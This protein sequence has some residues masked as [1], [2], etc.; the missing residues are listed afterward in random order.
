[1]SYNFDGTNDWIG[2]TT[3][4][5]VTTFPCT[6]ACWFKFDIADGTLISISNAT[7]GQRYRL[8]IIASSDPTKDIGFVRLISTAGGTDN[9]IETTNHISPLVWGHACAVIASATSRTV[10][11][12]AADS[13]TSTVSRSVTGLNRLQI[14]SGRESSANIDYFDGQIADVGIWDR[15]LTLPEI[16][17]LARGVSCPLVSV[18]NLVFHAPLIRDIVDL[19]T[20]KLAL[21]NNGGATVAN[22]PRIYI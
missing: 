5:P 1:M 6:L 8:R 3:T 9:I 21:T 2:N 4:C 14:G 17:S 16:T 11:L 7:G 18:T 12:N 22:H 19:T 20:S 15:A 13:G 10:Y